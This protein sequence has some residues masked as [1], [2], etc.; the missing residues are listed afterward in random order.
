MQSVSLTSV[1]LSVSL[2]V[3]RTSAATIP[4]PPTL[5]ASK[6]TVCV[7]AL[8][9]AVFCAGQAWADPISFPFTLNV[10]AALG[11]DLLEDVFGTA[12]RPGSTI[13]AV[14]TVNTPNIPVDSSDSPGRFFL[15][16]FQPS[17]TFSTGPSTVTFNTFF[18]S[19][20]VEND[21]F[22]TFGP[23]DLVDFFTLVHPGTSNVPTMQIEVILEGPATGLN[24]DSFPNKETL[25]ALRDGSF[26]V[27]DDDEGPA[28]LLS[29]PARITAPTPEPVP[30][31]KSILLFASGAFMVAALRFRSRKHAH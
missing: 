28:L 18:A 14:F 26:R 22:T 24:S 8:L 7:L 17:W 30:E 2:P 5:A 16:K 9:I 27:V 15:D 1:T 21:V 13:R 23:R 29:G 31:P 4:Q 20:D 12:A 3:V 11:P 25:R 10:Q 19:M 6:G